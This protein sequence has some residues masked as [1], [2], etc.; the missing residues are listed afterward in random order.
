MPTS[1]K[2][3]IFAQNPSVRGPDSRILRSRVQVPYES[4][5]PGP[6]GCR[7]HVVD[8]DSSERVL[9][10]PKARVRLGGATVYNVGHHGSTNATPQ[11]LWKLVRHQGRQAGEVDGSALN[12]ER[13]ARWDAQ[14]LTGQRPRDRDQSTLHPRRAAHAC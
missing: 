13:E 6:R 11:S 12:Q 1:W 4:L 8:S 10:E 14:A 2:M 5:D 9:S 7:V 3:T